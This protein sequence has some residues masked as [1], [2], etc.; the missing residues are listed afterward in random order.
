M[1]IEYINKRNRG[2][3]TAK[4]HNNYIYYAGNVYY[5]LTTIKNVICRKRS[6]YNLFNFTDFVM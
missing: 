6:S 4:L 5:L 1:R 2:S 3:T